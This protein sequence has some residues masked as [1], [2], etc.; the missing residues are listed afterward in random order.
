VLNAAVRT[1]GTIYVR[2]KA[3]PVT[4]DAAKRQAV[5]AE[6]WILDMAEEYLA[7]VHGEDAS[8]DKKTG[9]RIAERLSAE[10]TASAP[11]AGQNPPDSSGL[12]GATSA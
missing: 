1:F 8:S 4:W 6:A 9:A 10:A 7:W 11:T 5:F 3:E 12:R 2:D